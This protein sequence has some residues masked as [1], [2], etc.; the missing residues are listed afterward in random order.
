VAKSDVPLNTVVTDL[1]TPE[2]K[3]HRHARTQL[4]AS[5]QF[6]RQTNVHSTGEELFQKMTSGSPSERIDLTLCCW[7]LVKLLQDEW[8]DDA[9]SKREMDVMV[10]AADWWR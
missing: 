2:Q 9:A 1:Q 3:D 5:C 7:W 4:P 10:V 6:D 8:S